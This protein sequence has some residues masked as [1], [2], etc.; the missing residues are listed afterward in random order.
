MTDPQKLH[1]EIS[2]IVL[3]AWTEA[4]LADA[5]TGTSNGLTALASRLENHAAKLSDSAAQLAAALEKMR[6]ANAKLALRMAEHK[7]FFAKYRPAQ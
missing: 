2:S 3:H 1:V 4:Y 6:I 7:A 5:K